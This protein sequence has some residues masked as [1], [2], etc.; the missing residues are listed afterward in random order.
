MP[1]PARKIEAGKGI[2][3]SRAKVACRGNRSGLSVP[4][5]FSG[6]RPSRRAGPAPFTAY[7]AA[8]SR[9]ALIG[10]FKTLHNALKLASRGRQWSVSQK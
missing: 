4:G 5:G 2:G 6:E 3:N 7:P 10:N 8:I 1:K 9:V